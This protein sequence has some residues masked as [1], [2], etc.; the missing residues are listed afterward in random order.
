MCE[1][2]QMSEEGPVSHCRESQEHGDGCF[3]WQQD[4]R[5]SYQAGCAYVIKLAP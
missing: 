4:I 5:Y 3:A 2:I 1:G